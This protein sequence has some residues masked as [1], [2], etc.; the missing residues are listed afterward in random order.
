MDQ[1]ELPSTRS[2][3]LSR[4]L[5]LSELRAQDSVLEILG[6]YKLTGNFDINLEIVLKDL[7]AFDK[8]T[9]EIE[10]ESPLPFHTDYRHV[11][12]WPNENVHMD[13]F[14]EIMRSIR[15]QIGFDATLPWWVRLFR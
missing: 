11:A 6:A 8:V 2:S 1:S 9:Y 12:F 14:N 5:D 10:P 4:T 7:G 15:G 13:R 3:S